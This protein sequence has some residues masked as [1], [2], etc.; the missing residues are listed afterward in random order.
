M[1]SST[2]PPWCERDRVLVELLKHVVS[3]TRA[4]CYTVTT[5]HDGRRHVPGLLPR[6]DYVTKC[7]D[8][9]GYL[10]NYKYILP[11]GLSIK[12]YGQ[13]RLT[14]HKKDELGRVAVC[15]AQCG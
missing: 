1:V 5:A 10:M 11:V 9:L 8:P 12:M 6:L 3:P 7:E 14:I 4:V 15:T 2:P 13:F